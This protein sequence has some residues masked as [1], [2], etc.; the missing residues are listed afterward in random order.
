M[1]DKKGKD[2]KKGK[3]KKTKKASS[4]SADAQVVRKLNGSI[5]LNKLPQCVIMKKKN[6][7]GKTIEGVFLPIKGNYINKHENGG[8]YLE[9]TIHIK[10][11]KDTFGQDGFIGHS[12]PSVIYKAASDKEKEKMQN[13]Q[14]FGNIIDWGNNSGGSQN[15]APA[16]QM[17]EDDDL[18]F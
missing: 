18:P 7:K 3:E 13:T 12:V 9:M 1:A 6:K 5:D 16:A 15:S 14:I 4:G 10:D 17:D 2:K 8:L 11:Q